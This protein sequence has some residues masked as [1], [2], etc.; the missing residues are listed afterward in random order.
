MK[1]LRR[2]VRSDLAQ[3]GVSRFGGPRLWLKSALIGTAFAGSYAAL[4]A[5]VSRAW[6]VQLALVVVMHFAMFQTTIGIAH[7][8][9]HGAY[10]RSRRVNAA[11]G[12][13]FDL[14]GIDSRY[15]VRTHVHA[16]HAVPNVP[17][18]DSAIESFTLLRLHPKTRRLPIHAFQHVYVFAIYALVTVFQVYLLEPVALARNLFRFRDRE[19]SLGRLAGMAGTKLLVLGYSFV[20]PVLVVDAPAW[21]TALACLAGHMVCGLALGVI[22]QTT[23]LARDTEFPEADAHSYVRHVLLTT[24]EVAPDSALFTFIA[25]GLNLHVAHHLFPEISQVHLPRIARIVKT[26]AA[27]YGMPYREYRLGEAIASHVALMKRLG[28]LPSFEA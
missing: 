16:H 5:N 25:G 20:I 17:L 2:R 26:T 6:P 13:L 3:A 23:H 4:L 11:L 24:A 8:A 27:E 7:D 19:T 28:G 12:R 9:I 14:V 22:F 15:W 21:R 10:A 1:E 18:E